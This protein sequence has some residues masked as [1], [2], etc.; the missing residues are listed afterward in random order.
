VAFSKS[1]KRGGRKLDAG[2]RG[3]VIMIRGFSAKLGA[4]LMEKKPR[5][6]WENF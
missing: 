1:K 4:N 5:V 6:R 2:E 3:V